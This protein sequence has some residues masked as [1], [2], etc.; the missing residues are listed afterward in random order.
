MNPTSSTAA[1]RIHLLGV[2]GTGMGAFASLLQQAGYA[3]TGSD[4]NLYPPMSEMLKQWGIEAMTPY[5]PENLDRARP[6]LVVVGNVI[7]RD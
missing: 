2:G 6:D 5:A 4:Q 3:V 7:R 1:R